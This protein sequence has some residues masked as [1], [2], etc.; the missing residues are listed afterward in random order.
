MSGLVA[1]TLI[2]GVVTSTSNGVD[3]GTAGRIGGYLVA[4]ALDVALVVAAFRIL[5]S[6]RVSLR[7][8]LPGGLVAGVAFF[9]LQEASA[10]IIS[11]HLKNAQSTYG[12]FATVITIL[13]WFYLQAV[14]TLL[15]AQLNVV[16]DD[17]LY[18]RS[19][20]GPPQTEADNRA[21]QARAAPR[22]PAE[23]DDETG[24]AHVEARAPGD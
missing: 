13:W 23:D 1:A 5:T 16:L 14:I 18:P 11:G 2:S 20:T 6:R 3:L 22:T 8:V 24:A 10:V 21:L 4:V 7:D 9:I 12:H 19:I 15:A 17:R